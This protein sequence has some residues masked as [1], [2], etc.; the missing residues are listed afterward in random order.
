MTCNFPDCHEPV[1][2]GNENQMCKYHSHVKVLGSYVP[3]RHK[4]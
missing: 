2:K 4:D 1:E 3:D